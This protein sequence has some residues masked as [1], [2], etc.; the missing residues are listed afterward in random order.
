[1]STLSDEPRHLDD[2]AGAELYAL[3]E[4]L[5]PIGRS[6]T[7]AG[8]RETLSIL[9]ELLPGL[10]V[11]EVPSG[12]QAFDWTVPDEWTVR[13]AYLLAPDGTR[14]ADY[15]EHNLHLLGYSAPVDLELSLDEL[16]PHLL[17]RPDLPD[18]IP[19]ATSYYSP[20]WAFCLAHAQRLA[21]VPGTYR[22][23]IDTTL[24][25]GSLTYGELVVPGAT[26]REILVS[27]YVCHP[28]M[29]N[30]EVSGIVVACPARPVGTL[31]AAA[32]HLPVSLRT[33]DDRGDRLPQSSPRPPEQ[34]VVAGFQVTCV[35][36][37]RA[38]SFL[39]SRRGDTLADR[40]ARHV[41]AHHAER[42]TYY[43]FLDRGSDE[44]QWCSPGVDL[45]VVS[46]M[47]SKYGTYPEYHTSLDDLAFI[48]PAGLAGSAA[49]Y[50]RCL[51]LLEANCT[52]R[53]AMPCEPQLSKHDLYPSLSFHTGTSGQDRTLLDFLAYCD[54]THDLIEIAELIGVDALT[55]I[56]IARVLL[57]RDLIV[58]ADPEPGDVQ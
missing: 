1:L 48:S 57:E 44:R 7:G 10:D 54:G 58:P 39:P 49:L 53:T 19:Y 11:V 38:T 21:L 25:P 41:L 22:A 16:Q 8:V 3:A 18:A 29:A 28:S 40:C 12:T 15:G 13:A 2:R 32:L 4:R 45:P 55:L 47:R 43:S 23:V 50:V 26:D 6:L 14:L 37:E 5:F 52:Y 33:R 30:N 36:D 17:S 51:E 27:T 35:G 56:P 9:G 46:L 20:H 31:C 42:V 34:A 24:A